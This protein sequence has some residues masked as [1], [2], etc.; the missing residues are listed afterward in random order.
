M[1]GWTKYGIFSK[2]DQRFSYEFLKFYHKT[3]HWS[4]LT[5]R[6][7]VRD[8]IEATSIAKVGQSYIYH[9]ND[10]YI[11]FWKIDNNSIRINSGHYIRIDSLDGNIENVNHINSNRHNVLSRIEFNICMRSRSQFF[12][13]KELMKYRI[14]F[15][16]NCVGCIKYDK[17]SKANSLEEFAPHAQISDTLFLL[18]QDEYYGFPIGVT[19]FER[20]E[21]LL[22]NGTNVSVRQM[23]QDFANGKI[24]TSITL[25]FNGI[26][27][28]IN[29]NGL[30]KQ[31]DPITQ[32]LAKV[33][34]IES[35]NI[36]GFLAGN[37]V[38][39][40]FNSKWLLPVYILNN[41]YVRTQRRI[42]HVQ[43]LRMYHDSFYKNGEFVNKEFIQME[44]NYIQL[45]SQEKSDDNNQ[46]S[47]ASLNQE[48]KNDQTNTQGLNTHH[49]SKV[50]Q[51]AVANANGKVSDMQQFAQNNEE[52]S[53]GKVEEQQTQQPQEQ[54]PTCIPALSHHKHPKVDPREVWD[55]N[56]VVRKDFL[57]EKL[58]AR[59]S[60]YDPKITDCVPHLLEYD[61][62][63]TIAALNDE[64]DT[65]ILNLYQNYKNN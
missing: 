28:L 32:Q 22:N 26:E 60:L 40:D 52:K 27:T 59:V 2:K 44:Y 11:P 31:F 65:Y 41:L 8:F 13:D 46:F 23:Q 35:L 55:M 17:W 14:E 10:K 30:H 63:L 45:S 5:G 47:L 21:I 29:K 12:I 19:P 42:V 6:S 62:S 24:K 37:Y 18:S 61:L 3:I 56:V 54:H 4:N 9:E 58:H 16:I 1:R 48:Q 36:Q 57:L 34:N 49:Q 51:T 39:L 20:E 53:D 25:D 15:I 50:I 7:N 43:D 38:L 64:T 33:K